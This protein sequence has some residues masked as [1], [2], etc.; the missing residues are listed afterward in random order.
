[1]RGR[2][3]YAVA[4][5]L[6]ALIPGTTTATDAIPGPINARVVSVYDGDTLTV[7]ADPWPG[8]TAHTKV[9][10]A[11]GASCPWYGVILKAKNMRTT[12]TPENKPPVPV[13][14]PS[15]TRKISK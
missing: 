14:D 9:R 1:M 13:Y 15:T 2:K 12:P 6:V 8:L 10:V 3:G 7:D 11:G 5:A 4:L